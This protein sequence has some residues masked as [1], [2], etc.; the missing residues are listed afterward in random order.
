[1]KPEINVKL[2]WAFFLPVVKLGRDETVQFSLPFA[3]TRFV[4]MYLNKIRQGIFFYS[5]HREE[6]NESFKNLYESYSYPNTCR[7][8]E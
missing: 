3:F 6:M 8:H 7:K 1:M 4:N 5:F 2:K